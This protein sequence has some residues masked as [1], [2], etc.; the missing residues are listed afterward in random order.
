[1]KNIKI[2]RA[3]GIILVG[4]LILLG[5]FLIYVQDYYKASRPAVELMTTTEEVEVL[6]HNPIHMTSTTKEAEIGI[7]FYPGGKVEEVAYTPLMYP[8]AESGYETFIVDMPFN[9]AVFDIDAADAIIADNPEINTWYVGGHSLGAAMAAIYVE[10]HLDNIEGLI[11]LAGYSTA[12]L[13][14][15]ELSVLSLYGSEDE[16]LDGE[17]MN[18]YRSNLPKDTTEVEIPGGNHAQ[19]GLYGEQDGDGEAKI[20]AEEQLAIT[21]EEMEAFIS[22]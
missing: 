14:Q 4:L 8:L 11:L 13:S 18:E 1:M 7:I 20:S 21:I 6:N 17:Q 10:D 9:L 3:L 22:K 2:K 15:T 12:D 16:V 5:A 19:F